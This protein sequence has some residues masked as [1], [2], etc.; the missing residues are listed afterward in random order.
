MTVAPATSSLMPPVKGGY[1]TPK[2]TTTGNHKGCASY[3]LVFST[4][5]KEVVYTGTKKITGSH[6][7]CVRYALDDSTL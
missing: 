4:Y 2:P 5:N 6:D 1:I 3:V 7:S